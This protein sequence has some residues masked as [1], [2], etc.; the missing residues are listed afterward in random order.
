MSPLGYDI[1][2]V[3][4]SNETYVAENVIQIT[5]IGTVVVVFGHHS[6]RTDIG[7]SIHDGGIRANI[8][9]L[10]DTVKTRGVTASRGTRRGAV[11]RLGD[12]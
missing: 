1:R 12:A 2:D 5:D 10:V 11:I 4:K 7:M 9:L 3:S 8:G 6:A